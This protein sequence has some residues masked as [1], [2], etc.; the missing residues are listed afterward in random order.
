[1]TQLQKKKSLHGQPEEVVP[2][3]A[4]H[5]FNVQPDSNKVSDEGLRFRLWFQ[6]LHHLFRQFFDTQLLDLVLVV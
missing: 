5:S 3:N 2:A 6:M 4:I 1:M